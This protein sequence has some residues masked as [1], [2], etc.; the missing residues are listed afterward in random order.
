MSLNVNRFFAGNGL[1]RNRCDSSVLDADI[2]HP[3]K[4]CFRIHDATIQDHDIVVLSD[5]ER[6]AK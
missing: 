1:L 6:S 3:I 5:G 4:V 2:S